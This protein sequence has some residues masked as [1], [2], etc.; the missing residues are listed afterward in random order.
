[1]PPGRVFESSLGQ[2]SKVFENG[3]TSAYVSL[4]I[5]SK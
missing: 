3:I 2:L 4:F 5:T 1:M